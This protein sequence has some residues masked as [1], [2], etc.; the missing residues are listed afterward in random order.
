MKKILA[1]SA[2]T[3]L[4][5]SLLGAC[6]RSSAER[7]EDVAEERAEQREELREDTQ[8]ARYDNP[9]PAAPEAT[10][11]GATTGLG[12]VAAQ[13]I[14][15]ARCAREQKC[16]NIG[17]DEDYASVEV[18]RQEIGKEWADELNAYDCPNGLIEKEL[19]ECLESVK[20]EDCASPFDTLG[21]VVAC[22]SG[23]ICKPH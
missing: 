15:E 19:N 2:V 7:Q 14:A 5:T 13:Q 6:E 16:G 17:P 23:D 1:C 3:L 20:A 21:R 11:G 22:G 9:T 8:E 18:C 12:T 4:S 10:R